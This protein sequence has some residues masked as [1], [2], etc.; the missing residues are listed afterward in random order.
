M[1]N[2]DAPYGLRVVD[3]EG[4]QVRVKRYTK[5]TA[6]V[7]YEGDPVKLVAAGTVSL[8]AAGD[9]LLGVA[10]EAIAAGVA[11]D[12]AVCDDPEAIFEI[13]ASGSTVAA[14]VGLNANVLAASGDAA[15]KRS[16]YELDTASQATTATLQLK[17]LGLSKIDDNAYGTDARLLV[18]INEHVFQAGTAGI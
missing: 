7:I 11:G 6:D 2:V 13:K 17:I 15:L 10:M 4:K 5:T 9:K 8:A 1:A 14:D 18:K 12:I 16:K 3:T